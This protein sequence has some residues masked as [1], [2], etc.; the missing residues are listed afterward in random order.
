MFSSDLRLATL[1]AA[2][3]VTAGSGHTEP[4]LNNLI[5][6]LQQLDNDGV[7][8]TNWVAKPDAIQNIVSSASKW[9]LAMATKNDSSQEAPI[10]E[11]WWATIRF[12]ECFQSLT[13]DYEIIVEHSPETRILL[14]C[15]QPGQQLQRMFDSARS[16]VAFLGH[17]AR[18]AG[19]RLV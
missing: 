17:C 13:D 8:D 19:L 3:A 18:N 1:E 11:A 6:E 10:L 7:H 15:V 5:S 9:L 16:I 14:A 4:D 12:V 2:Q